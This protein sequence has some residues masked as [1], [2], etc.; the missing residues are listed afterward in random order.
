MSKT[1]GSS[2]EIDDYIAAFTDEE[3]QD[4]AAAETALDL[5]TMLYRIRQEQG[6]G[7]QHDA[8]RDGVKR[9]AIGRLQKALSTSQMGTL[10]PYLDALGFDHEAGN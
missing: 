2:N 8:E 7:E 10:Q 6:P 9:R 3:C 5:A 1:S 4:Y